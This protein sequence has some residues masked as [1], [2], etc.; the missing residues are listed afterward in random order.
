MTKNKASPDD[1]LTSEQ[2]GAELG[3]SVSRV[4][5]LVREGRL[6]AIRHGWSWII[7]RGDLDLVRDR[8]PG[9]PRTK[10]DAK[11]QPQPKK[12]KPRRS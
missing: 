8:P 4:L 12:P 1:L 3:I 10:P 2:A 9:R 7:R 11:P 6:P 5:V